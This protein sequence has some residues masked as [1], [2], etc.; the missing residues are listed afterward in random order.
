MDTHEESYKFEIGKCTD[1]S[2]S[3]EVIKNCRDN[4]LRLEIDEIISLSKNAKHDYL[5]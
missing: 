2:D 5:E 1:S 4:F 3:L